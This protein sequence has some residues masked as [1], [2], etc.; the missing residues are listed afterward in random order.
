MLYV[1][2]TPDILIHA[3]NTCVMFG[4]N[5]ILSNSDS[6]EVK[7]VLLELKL[8]LFFFSS[9]L[10]ILNQFLLI[11]NFRQCLPLQRSLK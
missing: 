11:G 7:C 4:K 5:C 3:R 8:K 9:L 2:L 6:A 1:G 10:S